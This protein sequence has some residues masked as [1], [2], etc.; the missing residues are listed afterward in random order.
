MS[1]GEYGN[2]GYVVNSVPLASANQALSIG[3]EKMYQTLID[4]GG[5]TDTNA[6][7]AGRI[8]GALVGREGLPLQ[9][10]E[11]LYSLRDYSQIEK[12]LKRL[13][14]TNL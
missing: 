2:S 7:I 4:I 12:V 6:S 8:V 11:K 10:L 3:I 14:N 13:T 9:L 1:I 5:D